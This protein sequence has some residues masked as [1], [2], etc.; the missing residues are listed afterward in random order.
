M[1]VQHM[2]AAHVGGKAGQKVLFLELPSASTSARELKLMS[3]GLDRMEAWYSDSNVG[4]K[5]ALTAKCWCLGYRL[6]C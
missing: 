3:S 4:S 2:H 1:V 5:V 6:I